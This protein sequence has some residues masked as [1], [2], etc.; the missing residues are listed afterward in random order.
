MSFGQPSRV[1]SFLLFMGGLIGVL[2][3]N[4]NSR[5]TLKSSDNGRPHIY[6][7]Y[8]L[9]DVLYDCAT[10]DRGTD[11]VNAPRLVR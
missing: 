8:V 11:F 5:T 1:V 9:Q 4:K 7:I 6:H 2:K 10:W 3:T